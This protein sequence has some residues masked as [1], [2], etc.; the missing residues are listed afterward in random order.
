MFFSFRHKMEVDE[1]SITKEL[2][3]EEKV[4]IDD[5]HLW[6][7]LDETL[8]HG[9]SDEEEVIARPYLKEFLEFCFK[10]FVTVNIFTAASRSWFDYAFSETVQSLMPAN[11]PKFHNVWSEE[12]CT[13]V[14]DYHIKKMS[15][16][17][18]RCK[19]QGMNKHNTL[20][21]DDTPIT[22]NKNYANAI[23]ICSFEDPPNQQQDQ[24]LLKLMKFLPD[25]LSLKS[26]LDVEKRFWSNE[27]EK[28]M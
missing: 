5:K 18:I 21:V 10:H 16:V 2:F 6:L 22:Y 15:R 26:V 14:E 4:V 27:K 19:R 25:L 11:N 9:D 28:R 12:M 23:P 3:H 13:V 7:D 20:I 8:L 17:W 24:E 1:K